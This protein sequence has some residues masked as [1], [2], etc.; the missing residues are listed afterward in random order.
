M[1]LMNASSA[2]VASRSSARTDE[3]EVLVAS[4]PRASCA[5]GPRRLCTNSITVGTPARATSAASCSGPDGR[6]C[7]VPATSRIASSASSISVSSNRIG[8]MFQI[9]SH[10]T[11]MFSSRAKRSLASCASA[12]SSRELRRVEVALVE[13]LL[14][15]LDDRGDDPR[16]A[17]DA[18]RRADRAVADLGARS[19]RISSASF[20]AP[21]SASRRLSIGVEPACAAWPRP[22]DAASARRRRCRARRR[23]GGP[24]TRAPAPARCAARG[25]RPRSRAARARRARGRGRRRA[26]A[27]AS[28]S[29]IPSRSV[30]SRSSS[31]SRHRAGR[32][33]RAEERAA[34][35][36]A[37]LV[38]PVDEPHRR[39]AASPSAAIRRSTST[40]ATTFRQPSSQPPFGTES[41]WPPI[42]SARSDSPRSV[43]HW[44]PASSISSSAPGRRELRAQP[45]R[46]P[47][48]R[49]P[50]TRRAGRRSRRRSARA[51]PRARR[52]CERGRAAWRRPYARAP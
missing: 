39:P 35:A 29:A 4:C 31:W 44:L 20:A 28:G 7:D 46:A 10:S 17:D 40:P 24:A 34:E 19:S 52:R 43:N 47:A 51:A 1:P 2:F 26:R 11:S 25:R 12:S 37:L 41:M 3:L 6:R 15:G 32:G 48:P 14:G 21:A 13:Q 38:G 36:R 22:R 18:A 5:R 49:S 27:S 16:P 9:R 8:S 45:A 23:A 50:S 33:R 30:S 42:S